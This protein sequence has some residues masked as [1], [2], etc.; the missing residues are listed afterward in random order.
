M[1]AAFALASWS[2]EVH[3][4]PARV[5][6]LSDS[7][8]CEQSA[9]TV[10]VRMPLAGEE[11]RVVF[12]SWKNWKNTSSQS[13]SCVRSIAVA[14]GPQSIPEHSGIVNVHPQVFVRNER[15]F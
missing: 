13:V 5:V 4:E 11:W 9:P 7:V 15:I 1:R 12:W 10:G 8:A 3:E 6:R 2:G 14:I